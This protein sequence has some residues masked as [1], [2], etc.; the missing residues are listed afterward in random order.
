MRD[1]FLL[2][3]LATA[4]FQILG[5]VIAWLSVKRL[6][7]HQNTILLTE[8]IIMI[9]ISTEILVYSVS[10]SYKA[11]FGFIAGLLLVYLINRF[12]PHKHVDEKQRLSMLVFIAMCI[13]EFPEGVAFGSTYILNSGVGIFTAA[14]MAL[15]N[16]PEGSI[17]AM[18]YLLKHRVKK[19]FMLT[20]GTQVLY[21][22]GG[23]GAY[24]MLV[25]LSAAGQAISACIASGAMI[26]VAFEE[27]QFLR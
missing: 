21:I 23:I 2:I 20:A 13:H 4:V 14:L 9:I 5:M 16:I 10:I 6:A 8:L 17:V 22:L 26:F 19:A 11:I 12:V 15:H 24:F 27:L 7:K 3:L 1:Y 18:P 25:S